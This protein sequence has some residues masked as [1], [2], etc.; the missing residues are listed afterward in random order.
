[1]SAV[2][3]RIRG[4]NALCGARRLLRLGLPLLPCS[5]PV[6]PAARLPAGA[7]PALP[8]PAG[9]GRPGSAVPDVEAGED[10][11]GLGESGTPS[12]K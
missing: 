1:M 4:L 9:T 8:G 3:P 2:R 7:A 11:Q 12:A 5:L 6:L 10:P